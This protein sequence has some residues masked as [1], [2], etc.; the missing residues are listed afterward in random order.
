MLNGNQGREG[1]GSP[2]T[3]LAGD[4][5]RFARGLALASLPE[6]EIDGAEL[7]RRV[8]AGEIAAFEHL[9]LGH[10]D[11]VYG[12]L[13]A[14]LSDPHEA[15]DLAQAVFLKLLEPNLSYDCGGKAF[16]AW[17][18]RIAHNAAI[19]F[20]RKRA[21][22][23]PTAPHELNRRRDAADLK[24]SARALERLFMAELMRL[25]QKLGVLQRQVIVMR[26]MLD[27]SCAEIALVLDRTPASVRQAHRRALRRLKA[28]VAALAGE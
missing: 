8:Q 17:L 1:G 16:R 12:Y 27:L 26:Y 7:V 10:F 6:G 3:G 15:E 22:A 2:I 14:T 23:E 9:Y 13:S 18:F 11:H 5:E 19:D 20:L 24:A 21:W 25:I 4:S 28:P